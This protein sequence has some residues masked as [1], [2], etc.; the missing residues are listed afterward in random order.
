[1]QLDR[2]SRIKILLCA[3]IFLGSFLLF[4]IQPLISKAILPWFGGS[5]SVWI[6]A[7]LFFQIMLIVGYALAHAMPHMLKRWRKWIPV[8]LIIISLVMLP[9]LPE[10][11]WKPTSDSDPTLWI[12]TILFVSIGIPYLLL[13]STSPLVQVWWSNEVK[14]S[15]YRLYALSNVAALLALLTYPFLFE[16]AF[17]LKL[18]G[19]L[20]SL[21][22]AIFAILYLLCSTL[23]D[24]QSAHQDSSKIE[25]HSLRKRAWWIALP[26]TGSVLLLAVTNH[27]TQ[28]IAV[29]PLLWVAPLSVYLFTFILAFEHPR[30]YP[31]TLTTVLF[32]I[33]LLFLVAGWR[34]EIDE[35]LLFS[36]S[37]HLLSLFF[38]CMI[39]HGELAR[40][41]PESNG[42]TSFYLC[43]AFGGA[44][45]GFFVS[46]IAPLIF[47]GF[48]ELP[49]G[50]LLTG[51]FA[52]IFLFRGRTKKR[53]NVATFFLI[54]V[55]IE[56]IALLWFP[57]N[58]GE[59]RI[60]EASR[61]FYGILTVREK[62]WNT[63]EDHR[64]HLGHG[65][66][67]HG[68]QYVA[69]EKKHEPSSYYI[70]E[71]GIGLVMNHLRISS[72]RHV[73]VVGLGIGTV[74]AYSKEN[75]VFR[76][77]EIHPEVIRMAKQYFTY[78]ADLPNPY[79]II[80]GDARLSLESEESQKFDVLILDAFS[81]DAIPVHLL[82]KE[83]FELYLTHMNKGG[84]IVVHITNKHLDL[85]PVMERI[86]ELL[87]LE[88][89][90]V[91]VF[92][93]E[94]ETEYGSDWVL[95]SRSKIPAGILAKSHVTLPAG[96]TDIRLWTDDYSSIFEV[97]K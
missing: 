23:C 20:W 27:L 56:S 77:Y 35:F 3:T 89:A 48:S 87:D 53:E 74:A 39:C 29:V 21:G 47:S 5:P 19:S 34:G 25:S 13:S 15:P 54:F 36:I 24:A 69:E 81:S 61:S 62:D 67:L 49:L 88:S 46:I 32:S 65:N 44:L 26:A 78:L 73:G 40:L 30:W 90:E 10:V 97:L 76:F 52:V 75:D 9:I 82:T 86:S 8:V 57:S 6:A 66:I 14:S 42:L 83:A 17:S 72:G 85:Y 43:I 45:G 2:R 4:Q 31:R 22:F 50:F 84:I 63:P 92:E 55:L 95:L 1:M 58:D 41:K 18:Q 33:F 71:S 11:S 28:D 91:S 94:H 79:E 38:A 64:L 60:I 68:V 93:E 37:F 96:D 12:L 16:P 70:E 7:M 59:A 51:V 80:L